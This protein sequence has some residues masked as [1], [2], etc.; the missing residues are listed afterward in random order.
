VWAPAVANLILLPLVGSIDLFWIGQ[1]RDP[2]AIAGMGAA[3]QVYSTI[4]FLISFLP[5]VVTP[6]IAEEIARGRKSMAAK[7]VRE[8]LGFA[9][10]MG[11]CGTLALVSFPHVV[12]KLISDRPQ[13]LAEAIPYARI[14]GL[15][16]IATLCST[17]SFATFRGL[18]DFRTP[19]RVS[20]AAN[21]LNACLDPL[22]MFG[23]GL[24]VSGVA[25]TTSIAEL[26]SAVTFMP[27][28]WNWL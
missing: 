18:L 27:G 2:W 1:S 15:S 16:L 17:V 6:R 26:F 22:L 14:R 3:N 19:L 12:L 20:L 10:V 24:G 8:A 21:M 11:A 5:A 13:V 23:F 25:A 7:W 9:C 28:P 4:Y